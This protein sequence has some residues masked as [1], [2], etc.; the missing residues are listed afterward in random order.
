MLP[1]EE[2]I[3]AMTGSLVTL[4]ALEFSPVKLVLDNQSDDDVILY[5]STNGGGSMVQWHTFPA[6]EAIILDEDLYSIPKGS[7]FY[8]DGDGTGNFSISYFYL[9]E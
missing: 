8:A 9:K 5:I 3:E 2:L 1:G 6:A 7:V 4:G